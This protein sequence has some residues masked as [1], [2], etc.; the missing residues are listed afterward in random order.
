MRILQG[1]DGINILSQ[2]VLYIAL[3]YALRNEPSLSEKFA[4]LIQTFFV[5]DATKMNPNINFG[6]VVRGPGAAGRMGT[7]TGVLDWRGLVKVVNGVLIMKATNSPH[8]T[9][10]LASD[11][12][13]WVG[14]YLRWLPSSNLGRTAASRPKYVVFFNL[15][16]P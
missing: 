5:N 10:G 15:G 13:S 6:Q 12:T 14:E 2:A 4:N 9:S 16:N 3:G 1:P 8:W 11:M 7:F